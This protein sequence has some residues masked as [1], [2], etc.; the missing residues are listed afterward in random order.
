MEVAASHAA[1][2]PNAN[3][4]SLF[5]SL[6]GSHLSSSNVSAPKQEQQS[7]PAALVEFRQ[8]VRMVCGHGV[9]QEEV[10]T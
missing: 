3:P 4:D 8:E 2:Y 10:V 6:Y 5:D 9:R 7:R 1:I